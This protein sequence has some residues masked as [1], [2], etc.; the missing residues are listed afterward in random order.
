M[1]EKEIKDFSY[2]D[3]APCDIWSKD[4]ISLEEWVKV[5]GGGVGKSAKRLGIHR[6]TLNRYLTGEEKTSETV[7]IILA[8]SQQNANL[9]IEKAKYERHFKRLKLEVK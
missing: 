3:V 1:S 9:R 7:L 2:L 4:S 8:L 5:V 6:S